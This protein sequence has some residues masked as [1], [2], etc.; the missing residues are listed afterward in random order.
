MV[1]PWYSVKPSEWPQLELSAA[2][3]SVRSGG[4]FRPGDIPCHPGV[5]PQVRGGSGTGRQ[6]DRSR[7][8][9]SPTRGIFYVDDAAEEILLAAE[10]YNHS[11]PVNLGSSF[12]I[13]IK[14]LTE[15]IAQAT[16]FAGRIV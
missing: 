6:R 16:G 2:S 9:G 14:Q 5:D 7:G 15:T 4:R 10:R 11:D 8:D 3:D 13:S 12:E 1:D